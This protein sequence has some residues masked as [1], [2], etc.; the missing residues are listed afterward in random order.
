MIYS[1]N[2]RPMVRFEKPKLRSMVY[3]TLFN[4]MSALEG[5]L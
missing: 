5:T 4:V 2:V 1:D 3:V